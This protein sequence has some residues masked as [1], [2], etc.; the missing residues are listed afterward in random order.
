MVSSD[1]RLLKKIYEMTEKHDVG[2]EESVYKAAKRK[3]ICMQAGV[4][5][6]MAVGVCC[7]L[8]GMDLTQ[9][10]IRQEYHNCLAS[11]E[12]FIEKE[13]Y[14]VARD[15][16]ARA[17]EAIP[18]RIDAYTDEIYMLYI[19]KEYEKCVERGEKILAVQ[20]FQVITEA[21][22]RQYSDICYVMANAYYELEKYELAQ[23]LLEKALS[24]H[25]ENNLYYRDYAIVLARL[26]DYDEA[27]RQLKNAVSLGLGQDII[28]MAE[29]K[30]QYGKKNYEAA[31]ESFQ[32]AAVL[33]ID[34]Q[35]KKA[36]VLLCA[37]SYRKL[38]M[39]ETEICFLEEYKEQFDIM[40][41]T[42]LLEYLAEAYLWKAQLGKETE[43]YYEKALELLLLIQEQG[44]ETYQLSENIAILYENIGQLKMAEAELKRMS[45]RYPERYEVYKRLTY[46][47]ADRQQ[48]MENA[49]RDYNQMRVYYNQAEEL[50]S[51]NIQD[52]EMD[53]LEQMMKALDEGGW[54][55]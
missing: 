27:E 25:T 20:P 46:L 5:F 48:R 1:K 38:E 45:E 3:W 32:K 40:E 2:G 6:T 15:Y 43:F 13:D 47:E 30:I 24:Y 18:F 50:Y 35:L 16:L 41:N 9:K 51:E 19:S 54:F 11:A 53:M 37:D 42:E 28:H 33:T 55:E 26:G 10:E 31:V 17:Q 7:I 44:Y 36:A 49:D 22:R 4:I 39:V 29:G 34:G 14:A 12:A 52:L 8:W 23:R 21:D